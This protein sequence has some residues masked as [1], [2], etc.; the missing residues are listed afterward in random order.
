[1]LT[2]L[3]VDDDYRVAD[4]HAE[5][6]AST[7][8]FRALPP[9]HTLA[10]ARD[11]L[12]RERVD[13]LLADQFVQD[14]RGVD[15]VGAFPGDS[16]LI[17]ADRS[18][19]TTRLA[20]TRGALTVLYKPFAARELA[21]RLTAYARRR[22]ILDASGDLD[23]ETLDRALRAFLAPKQQADAISG[24]AT[25]ARFREILAAEPAGMTA[26]QVAEAAGVS[27]P[28]AQRHLAA[29]ARAGSLAL[30]L[31]YGSTGRPEHVYRLSGQDR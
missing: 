20:L 14:G 12:S 7:P 24:N 31:R 22:R 9:A 3:V 26:A 13:L 4:L 1:M 23:Q 29:G 15:L 27:R 16:I 28:T 19:A 18:R 6:V 30:E 2:V 8:G 25:L 21:D 10:A 11:T 5:I 17:T